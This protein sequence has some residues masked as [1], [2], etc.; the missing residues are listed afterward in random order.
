MSRST[1]ILVVI[2]AILF[3]LV[4]GVMNVLGIIG[5]MS[6]P[7]AEWKDYFV[8]NGTQYF[9]TYNIV[10]SAFA[11]E[12]LGEITL[13]VPRSADASAY[14]VREGEAVY[15]S[16]GTE[17]Y[18]LKGFSPESYVAAYDNGDYYLYCVSDSSPEQ[19]L[20]KCGVKSIRRDVRFHAFSVDTVCREN[21]SYGVRISVI[22]TS[23]EFEDYL[24]RYVNDFAVGKSAFTYTQLTEKRTYGN[25]FFRKNV[26]IAVRLPEDDGKIVYNLDSI[27]TDEAKMTLLLKKF[28]L[29]DTV[30]YDNCTVRHLFVEV[31]ADDYVRQKIT[32]QVE[33]YS[34]LE[35]SSVVPADKADTAPVPDADEDNPMHAT[36][37]VIRSVGSV[38][39][40][41]YEALV[42]GKYDRE[43]F[44]ENVLVAVSCTDDLRGFDY[45]F[46]GIERAGNKIRLEIRRSE[47]ED[48]ADSRISFFVLP[49]PLETYHGELIV[50]V[51]VS[52]EPDP[53]DVRELSDVVVIENTGVLMD[54]AG[55]YDIPEDIYDD[56]F[57][58]DHVLLFSGDLVCSDEIEFR[59]VSVTSSDGS[60]CIEIDELLPESCEFCPS[61][62]FIAIPYLRSELGEKELV[63][64]IKTRMNDGEDDGGI[65]TDIGG[66][67]G[68]LFN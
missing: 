59:Y 46:S 33:E 28:S 50:P 41:E 64:D 7:P 43:F 57:F 19:V 3:V 58:E 4:I 55:K 42:R 37:R 51:A 60:V 62:R 2:I 24:S 68:M 22:R 11:D 23:S 44:D 52:Q 47:R 25:S 34:V 54:L 49:L 39:G 36:V 1:N 26:L 48:A 63:A 67:F 6:E 27:T 14:Q 18:A 56:E 13:S 38:L 61:Y 8:L 15:L 65:P 66:Y 32:Y 45:S 16:V 30:T 12:K 9:N 31:S 17:I 5:D 40:T 20:A 35:D 29:P 21:T 10:D 53:D